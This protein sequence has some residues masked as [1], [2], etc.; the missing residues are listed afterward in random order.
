[1]TTIGQSAFFACDSLAKVNWGKNLKTIGNYAFA[2]SGLRSV[3]LPQGIDSIAYAA[4][5]GCDSLK[6]VSIPSS[7]RR[8]ASTSTQPIFSQCD[9]ID[10]IYWNAYKCPD[11]PF[12]SASNKG[13]R[14]VEFGDSIQNIPNKFC[15]SFS[16]LAKVI[17]PEGLQ[18]IEEYAFYSCKKLSTIDIPD[19]VT[20]IGQRAFFACYSLAEVNSHAMTP[21]SLGSNAFSKSTIT[22]VYIPCGTS[23]AYEASAWKNYCQNFVEPD[24]EFVFNIYP[25]DTTQGHVTIDQYPTCSND[26]VIFRAVPNS[27]YQFEQWSDGNTDNP[28]QLVLTQDTSLVAIFQINYLQPDT[29]TLCY[30]ETYQWNDKIYSSTGIYVDTLSNGVATLYLTILPAAVIETEAL[31]LCPSELPYEWYGQSITEA[32]LYTATEQ[33]AAGCDS[34]LHELTL[35][36]YLQT[37]PEQVTLPV[38]HQGEAIDV[39]I[40]T[41]E[42]QAHIAAETWY[43]PNALVEWY[44]QTLAGWEVLT[45]EPIKNGTSQI[46]LKYAVNSDCGSVESQGMIISV[47]TTGVENLPNGKTSPQKLIRDGQLLIMRDGKTYNA[48][49]A[50]L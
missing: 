35:D 17:L 46:V 36:V 47:L 5:S 7:M 10:S 15:Q 12:L 44:M 24:V 11:I 41:A 18:S 28:R 48:Q 19:S 26:T 38:V 42:V 30:G 34:I 6:V 40:P 49:G 14:V 31:A 22:S 1:M 32:G 45:T 2:Y 50:A 37:L 8:M 4:F 13:I 3:I 29:V 23:E 9:A 39:T 43:A 16:N 27:I 20:T 25:T 21:P 33:Y